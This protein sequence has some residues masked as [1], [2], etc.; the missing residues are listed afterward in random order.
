LTGLSNRHRLAAYLREKISAANTGSD[1]I[2]L[3][4]IGLDGFQ[5]I[6][7]MLG[8]TYGD[9]VLRAVA[10]RFSRF[11]DRTKLV[12]RLD[13]DEFAMVVE[14]ANAA[15]KAKDLA[16]EICQAFSDELPAVEARQQQITVS[17]G[18]A[19]FPEK[20]QDSGRSH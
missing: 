12:A 6:V 19:T 9:K 13:G 18:L 3:L 20:L 8:H 2:T 11:F 10:A 7:D 5:F 16:K 15:A 1:E 14:G 4:V 17:I